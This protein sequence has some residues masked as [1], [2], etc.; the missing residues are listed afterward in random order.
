MSEPTHIRRRVLG[1][2]HCDR[3]EAS[4]TPFTAPFYDY[5]TRTAWEGVWDRPG[6]E[7]RTRSLLTLAVLTALRC[8]SELGMHV[9]VDPAGVAP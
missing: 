5:V 1:D 8:E 9:A 2:A 6:L 4:A 3:T 7:L